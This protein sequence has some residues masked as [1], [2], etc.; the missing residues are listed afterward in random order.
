M[1][2]CPRISLAVA[3]VVIVTDP[4]VEYVVASGQLV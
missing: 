4:L 2:T 3:P 1:S